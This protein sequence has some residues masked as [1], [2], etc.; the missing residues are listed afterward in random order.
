[1]NTLT[2]TTNGTG[3]AEVVLP[4]GSID[5]TEILDA[6]ILTGDISTGGKKT[7]TFW[8]TR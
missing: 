5:S 2:V 4:A 1:M 6:T 7:G 3:T 8:M